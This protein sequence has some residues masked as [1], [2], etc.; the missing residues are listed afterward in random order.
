MKLK[1]IVPF[2]VLN[3]LVLFLA[4]ACNLTNNNEPPTLVPRVTDTPLP[5]IAIETP[6]PPPVPQSNSSTQNQSQA[7]PLTAKANMNILL[8]Q[9]DVDHLFMH[10]SA[11][12]KLGTRHVNSPDLPNSGVAAAYRY[13]R[14][15]FDAIAAKSN[16]NFSV[17]DQPFNLKWAG[18]ETVQRNIIGTIPGTAI[19]GGVIVLCAHYDSISIDPNDPSYPEPGSR[20]PIL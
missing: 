12:E 4:A 14:G 13:V 17:V 2:L 9:V 20:K 5:P 18:V 16:G 15:E 11:L 19:G 1:P 3:I 8:D 6:V 10:V 7:N